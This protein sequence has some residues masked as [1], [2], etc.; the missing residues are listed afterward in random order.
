MARGR[1][2]FRRRIRGWLLRL[3]LAWIGISVLVVL[4][5]R[6]VDPPTTAFMLAAQWRGDGAAS[7]WLDWEQIPPEFA[8][9]VVAAEDQRFPGHNGF[10]FVEI[11][12]AVETAIQ[13]GRVRGASTISQQVAKNLFLWSGR[14]FLRKGLEA[15][16]TVLLEALW[17]KRRI[18]EV[19]LNI[20]QFGDGFYGVAAASRE[21]FSKTPGELTRREMSLLASVLPDPVDLNP[22][23]PGGHL[24][25]R[26]A[27]VR[28]HMQ[29]LGGVGYI[30][31][32]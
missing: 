32:M 26:A 5:F 29:N 15:Y 12:Q 16:F 18:L 9:A 17:P 14:S 11:Q 3:A 19:Y 1:G 4:L 24:R 2:G 21:Y 8:L 30:S 6:W 28:R 10:D 27:F 25:D 13:G 20:A 23:A 22:A 7:E 31:R